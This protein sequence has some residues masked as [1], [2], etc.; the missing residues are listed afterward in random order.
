MR[1]APTWLR[2]VSHPPLHKT[3]LTTGRGRVGDPVSV[4]VDKLICVIVAMT[5][6]VWC[7]KGSFNSLSHA[8]KHLIGALTAEF[9]KAYG[10]QKAQNTQQ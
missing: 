7:K 10:I 1:F 2:Q 8:F 4:N 5:V 9:W 3:T 6:K